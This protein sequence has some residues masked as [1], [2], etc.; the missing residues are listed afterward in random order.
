MD[1]QRERLKHNNYKKQYLNEKNKTTSLIKEK[2]DLENL[3]EKLNK[4]N[5]ILK[6]KMSLFEEEKINLINNLNEKESEYNSNKK[7]VVDLSNQLEDLKSIL[8]Q[9]VEEVGKL[10]LKITKL[11]KDLDMT[12]LELKQKE[13]NITLLKNENNDV[14]STMTNNIDTNNNELINI[15]KLNAELFD[16][17]SN[18]EKELNILKHEYKQLNQ[19]NENLQSKIKSLSEINSNNDNNCNQIKNKYLEIKKLISEKDKEIN[20]LNEINKA[21]IEKEK[22]QVE[23]ESNVD[24]NIYDII[25][26]K[27]YKNLTWYLLCKKKKNK[28]KEKEKDNNNQNKIIVNKE[29]S[30]NENNYN[31]Y[32][33]VTGLIVKKDK[34]EKFNKFVSDE[35]Y[36]SL[37]Q[38]KLEAKVE[39]INKKD[40]I[41]KKLK[42]QINNSKLKG[43]NLDDNSKISQLQNEISKLKEEQKAKEKLDSGIKDLKIIDKQG[44]DS[45]FFDEDLKE[46]KSG[47]EMD[48]INSKFEINELNSKRSGL[49]GVSIRSQIS[50]TNEYKLN[51][52]KNDEFRGKKIYL[53]SELDIEKQVK[54]QLQLLKNENKELRYKYNLLIEQIKELLKNIKCDM[55]NKPQVSQ[56]C[57]I[58]GYSPQTINK[59]VS[60]NKKVIV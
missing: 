9:K 6:D 55:K 39:S 33:W 16:G 49:P 27:K 25:T 20:R 59:V 35:E 60:N 52:G 50:S 53:D 7:K 15:K 38:K 22:I 47:I 10:K 2:N 46:N 23:K 21:L 31:S 1:R 18:L 14:I 3:N 57:Q 41:I 32:R 12:K 29:E 43:N 54:E 45:D 51:G 40:F 42:E 13:E 28:E 36:I 4:E 8:N 11:E 34:L 37:F 48:L 56:I 44:D 58:L 19:E 17:K 30:K 26:S 24:P 5:K